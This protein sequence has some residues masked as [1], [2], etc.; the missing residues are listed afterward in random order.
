MG[1]H[2]D[3]QLAMHK[4]GSLLMLISA[5]KRWTGSVLQEGLRPQASAVGR[6][7][8]HHERLTNQG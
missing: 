4:F 7:G 8:E 3:M 2:A 1:R 5:W 6:R